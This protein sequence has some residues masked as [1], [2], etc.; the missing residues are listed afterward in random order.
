MNKKS[1]GFV[2][3]AKLSGE[4]DAFFS[5]DKF[6]PYFEIEIS[7]NFS[8]KKLDY[9]NYTAGNTD[10][11]DDYKLPDI[12]NI[13]L[14]QKLLRINPFNKLQ[15][16]NIKTFQYDQ[17]K[18]FQEKENSNNKSDEQISEE[19]LKFLL[20]LNNKEVKKELKKDSDIIFNSEKYEEDNLILNQRAFYNDNNSS[21]S[22]FDTRD[23]EFNIDK[24]NDK[25]TQK[26]LKNTQNIINNTRIKNSINEFEYDINN[27]SS[28][29]YNDFTNITNTSNIIETVKNEFINTVNETVNKMEKKILEQTVSNTH[30]KNIETNIVQVIENKLDEKEKSII[31][32]IDNKQK[33]D[34]DK[35]KHNFLNS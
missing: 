24:K 14:P 3:Y 30:I 25:Q 11:P 15:D 28:N 27:N 6:K 13:I 22:S 34:L 32:K 17:K 1:I 7:Q 10:D 21:L 23:F 31:E 18:Y 16:V 2:R 5:S 29:S 4:S 9:E 33:K 8:S 19:S 20:F 35:F 26:E 12:E